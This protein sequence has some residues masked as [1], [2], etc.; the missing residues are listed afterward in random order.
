MA[1]MC[2]KVMMCSHSCGVTV[3]R[4]LSCSSRSVV[5]IWCAL[6]GNSHGCMPGIPLPLLI[7]Y[8][9]WKCKSS[10]ATPTCKRVWPHQTRQPVGLLYWVLVKTSSRMKTQGVDDCPCLSEKLQLWVLR[11]KVIPINPTYPF[12]PTFLLVTVLNEIILQQYKSNY[13]VCD[14]LY[15]F[16]RLH[17]SSQVCNIMDSSYPG[18]FETMYLVVSVPRALQ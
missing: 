4:K 14:W 10:V 17:F 16:C 13:S 11:R 5:L 7:W 18:K 6:N 8:C 3:T 2:P 1:M 15:L 12:W 9:T